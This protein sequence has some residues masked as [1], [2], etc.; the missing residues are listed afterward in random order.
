M[1]LV[2]T[3]PRFQQLCHWWLWQV[4]PKTGF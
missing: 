2:S 3:K 4:M 1:S